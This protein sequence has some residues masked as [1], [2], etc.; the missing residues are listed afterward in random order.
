MVV[1]LCNNILLTKIH[2]RCAV[3]R[4]NSSTLTF[5]LWKWLRRQGGK[6]AWVIA[7]LKPYLHGVVFHACTDHVW[8]DM[9]CK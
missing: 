6:L 3:F 2:F 5:S 9:P 7:H 1:G 4:V 8:Q